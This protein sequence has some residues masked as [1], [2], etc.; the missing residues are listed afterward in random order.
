MSVTESFSD[1]ILA[2]EDNWRALTP[3]QKQYAAW[4]WSERMAQKRRLSPEKVPSLYEEA[5]NQ[6]QQFESGAFGAPR[7]SGSD[8]TLLNLLKGVAQTPQT[9]LRI[10]GVPA[11]IPLRLAKREAET[12]SPAWQQLLG[13]P[14]LRAIKETGEYVLGQKPPVEPPEVAGSAELGRTLF[15]PL[16][17]VGLGSATARKLL[18]AAVPKLSPSA[19]ARDP[20]LFSGIIQ[21]ALTKQQQVLYNKLLPKLRTVYTS[22]DARALAESL[23]RRDSPLARSI[24]AAK[25]AP[26]GMQ[27]RALEAHRRTLPPHVLSEP[28]GGPAPKPPPTPPRPE[29]A[30]VPKK[31]G[32]KKK[33]EA[34]PQPSVAEEML[35]TGPSEYANLLAELE[36]L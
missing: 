12:P 28:I 5:L 31:R 30:P 10:L 7:K 2:N 33:V 35:R 6:M 21:P 16:L 4:Y 26:S 25:E 32:R 15:D 14:W 13:I 17:Y 19:V 29:P 1:F 22:E 36:R 8:F 3:E 23:A 24:A 27:L 18:P 11:E 34:E 9:A 20:E